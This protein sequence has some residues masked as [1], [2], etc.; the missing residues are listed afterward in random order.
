MRK[1]IGR[2]KYGNKIT[3]VGSTRFD[4]KREAERFKDLDI[5]YKANVISHLKL[6]PSFKI[7]VKGQKICTYKADFSYLDEKGREIIEDVKGVKT[8]VYRI[9]KKLV[10][11]IFDVKITEVE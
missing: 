9:K 8:P 11:A 7:E 10:E 4:S 5:L 6:Q 3:Y 2:S 1:K